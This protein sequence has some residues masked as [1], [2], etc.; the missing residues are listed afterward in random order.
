M[1]K[2]NENGMVESAHYVLDGNYEVIYNTTFNGGVLMVIDNRKWES[3]PIG[4]ISN[5]GGNTFDMI[6]QKAKK[7]VHLFNTTHIITFSNGEQNFESTF[8]MVA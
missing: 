2:L 1:V 6:N 4:T 3:M 8:L 7:I 5:M